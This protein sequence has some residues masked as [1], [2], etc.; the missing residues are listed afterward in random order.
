MPTTTPAPEDEGTNI[1][2][3]IGPILGAIVIGVTIYWF[4]RQR[5]TRT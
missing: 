4:L 5:M 3:I 1:W 2:V